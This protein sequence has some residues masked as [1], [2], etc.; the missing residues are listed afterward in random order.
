[1][2]FAICFW[3]LSCS[4][5][6]PLRNLPSR[7]SSWKCSSCKD[8][9]QVNS[10]AEIICPV[11]IHPKSVCPGSPDSA[12]YLNIPQHYSMRTQKLLILLC[13]ILSQ[14]AK[15]LKMCQ[16]VVKKCHKCLMNMFFFSYSLF[17]QIFLMFFQ[18]STVEIY[19]L[20]PQFFLWLKSRLRKLFRF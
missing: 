18:W 19:A 5:E 7:S 13:W 15:A 1:M 17:L 2:D 4:Q 10:R 8:I 9:F 6:Y 16:N 3:V 11:L 12:N 14:R 20:F